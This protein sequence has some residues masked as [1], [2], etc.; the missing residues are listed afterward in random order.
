MS[1]IFAGIATEFSLQVTTNNKR[2][3]ITA[4]VDQSAI[5]I[6]F[7][8]HTDYR[9]HPTTYFRE[10]KVRSAQQIPRKTRMQSPRSS[11]HIFPKT[12]FMCCFS[13]LVSGKN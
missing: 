12:R 8:G 11:C 6:L 7:R 3:P 1:N 4:K 9:I 13:P 5:L 10:M 2:D